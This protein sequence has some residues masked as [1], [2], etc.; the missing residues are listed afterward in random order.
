MQLATLEQQR[1]HRYPGVKS[2]CSVTAKHCRYAQH[3]RAPLVHHGAQRDCIAN[4]VARQ[5]EAKQQAVERHAAQHRQAMAAASSACRPR[6]AVRQTKAVVD[7][8]VA[9]M[10][11]AKRLPQAGLQSRL[12]AQQL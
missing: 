6:G 1:H 2:L 5:R 7:Q 4:Y 3:V 11:A 9:R 10:C 12:A 8:E